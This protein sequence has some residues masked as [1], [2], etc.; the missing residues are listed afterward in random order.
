MEKEEI[1]ELSIELFKQIFMEAW[2]YYDF[3]E[4]TSDFVSKIEQIAHVS[5]VGATE[6]A[7]K[8]VEVSERIDAVER[9]LL[10]NQ[11]VKNER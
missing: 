9:G 2:K 6:F 10:E 4:E 8:W 5:H 7:L 1:K 11:D 3:P